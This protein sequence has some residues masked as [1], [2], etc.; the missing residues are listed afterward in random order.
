MPKFDKSKRYQDKNGRKFGSGVWLDDSGKPI[1]PGHGVY[2]KNSKTVRQYNSD[3]TVTT[4]TRQDW[5]QKQQRDHEV[6]VLQNDR[7]YARALK[8]P[9]S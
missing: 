4:F 9:S 3:G 2:D 8:N 1:M 6:R 5:A 7:K